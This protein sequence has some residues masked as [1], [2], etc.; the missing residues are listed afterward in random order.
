MSLTALQL[1]MEKH[2]I[3]PRSVGR[4]ATLCFLSR[5]LPLS[6]GFGLALGLEEGAPPCCA[7]SA[8]RCQVSRLLQYVSALT[9]VNMCSGGSWKTRAASVVSAP[10]PPQDSPFYHVTRKL[11]LGRHEE[12]KGGGGGR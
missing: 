1:L 3:D 10:P 11:R 9:E 2:G 12:E 5:H 7:T 4:C 6:D 8:S